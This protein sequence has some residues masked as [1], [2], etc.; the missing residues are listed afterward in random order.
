MALTPKNI[1][2]VAVISFATI[3]VAMKVNAT[4][5]ILR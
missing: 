5:Q 1:G 3:A 2:I 4:R